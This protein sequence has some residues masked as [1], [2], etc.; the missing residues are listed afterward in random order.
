MGNKHS[1]NKLPKEH[2]QPTNVQTG[3]KI[4]VD[5]I[6]GKLVGV[7]KDLLQYDLDLGKEIDKSKTVKTSN[8]PEWVQIT[9]LPDEIIDLINYNPPKIENKPVDVRHEIHIEIDEKSPYGLR[10]LPEE[11]INRFYK[12]GL[13]ENEVKQNPQNMLGIIMGM[14]KESEQELRRDKLP[15]NEEFSKV[16]DSIVF[17]VSI[18]LHPVRRGLPL[19]RA[20]LKGF[21]VNGF[22]VKSFRVKSFRVK[23]F[24]VKGFRVRDVALP[25]LPKESELLKVAKRG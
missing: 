3:I 18:R 1:K 6:T 22:R 4:S 16:V 7:P 23:S 12:N 2:N 21:R 24:R 25:I 17:L 13:T 10:G 5:P 9:E 19:F 14:E 15:T 8:L 11:W 20:L